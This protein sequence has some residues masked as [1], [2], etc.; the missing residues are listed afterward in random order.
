MRRLSFWSCAIFD[1][2]DFFAYKSRIRLRD[3]RDF[4]RATFCA[5]KVYR[6]GSVSL[7]SCSSS[8]A[9]LSS[10]LNPMIFSFVLG[11]DSPV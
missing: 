6:S 2:R 1:A 5:L 7:C 11:D 3:L 8:F 4:V 10:P 9:S